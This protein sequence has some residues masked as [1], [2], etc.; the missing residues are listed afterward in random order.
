[1][2][3]DTNFPFGS[4]ARPVAP[5]VDSVYH[6]FQICATMSIG[7]HHVAAAAVANSRQTVPCGTRARYQRPLFCCLLSIF[8][9]PALPR[10]LRSLKMSVGILRDVHRE[11]NTSELQTSARPSGSCSSSGLLLPAHAFFRGA[12]KDLFSPRILSVLPGAEMSLTFPTA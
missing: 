2:Q 1:M 5:F 9:L 8:F 11:I 3:E 12:G 4:C 7:F 6:I 10:R